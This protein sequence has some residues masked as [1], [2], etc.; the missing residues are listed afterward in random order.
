M[1][2]AGG[3]TAVDGDGLAADE[4]RVTRHQESR[5]GGDLF[6]VGV[7]LRLGTTLHPADHGR[8]QTREELANRASAEPGR[9]GQ[10]RDVGQR[11]GGDRDA[12]P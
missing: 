12:S 4:G 6:R 8:G 11:L 3:V 9:D 7:E 2:T 10:Q 1:V 5:H